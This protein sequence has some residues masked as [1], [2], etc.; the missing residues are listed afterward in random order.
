MISTR[1]GLFC[2]WPGECGAAFRSDGSVAGIRDSAA[3]RDEHEHEVHGYWHVRLPEE[4][5]ARGVMT[6]NRGRSTLGTKDR[7]R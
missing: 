1:N 2:R 5:I 4:Q 7:L 6:T 3:T